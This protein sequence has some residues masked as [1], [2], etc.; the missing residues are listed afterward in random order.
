MKA[1]VLAILFGTL[2]GCATASQTYGPDGRVSYVVQCDG[3]ANS[4]AECVKKSG[5]LCGSHGYDVIERDGDQGAM[6]VANSSGAYA[7]SVMTRSMTI[8]CHQ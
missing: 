6:G 4:W 7:G 8:S 2:A 1:F 3:L 5:E